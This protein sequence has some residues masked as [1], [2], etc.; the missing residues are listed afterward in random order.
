MLTDEEYT[1]LKEAL[2]YLRENRPRNTDSPTDSNKEQ[3]E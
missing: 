1:Y 3:P 2:E